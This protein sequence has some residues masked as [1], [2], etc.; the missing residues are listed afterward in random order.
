MSGR[1]LKFNTKIDIFR[2]RN[3]KYLDKSFVSMK[4]GGGFF[5]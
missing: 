2:E 3:I 4:S 5:D 1:Y